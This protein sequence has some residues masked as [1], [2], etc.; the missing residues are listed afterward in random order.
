VTQPRGR[1]RLAAESVDESRVAGKRRVQD[2]DRDL[3]VQ[4]RVARAEDLAHPSRGDTIDDVVPAVE[5]PQR[6]NG[7]GPTEGSLRHRASGRV[8]NLPCAGELRG[9]SVR[10][11]TF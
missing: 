9:P 10:P 2:L 4:D 3:T 5:G 11:G 7:I 1:A 8:V 6:A